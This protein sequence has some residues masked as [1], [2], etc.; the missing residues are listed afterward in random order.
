MLNLVEI[1]LIKR[2][3]EKLR[4][5]QNLKAHL[6]QSGANYVQQGSAL[7]MS[8]VLARLLTPEHFGQFAFAMAYVQLSFMPI[9]FGLDQLLVSKGKNEGDYP[10]VMTV[11]YLLTALGIM[12]IAG[13]AVWLH[14]A[15]K[16]LTAALCVLY[17][18]PEALAPVL[19]AIKGDLE[20]SGNFRQNMEGLLWSQGAGFVAAVVG[21]LSGLGVYALCVP[22]WLTVLSRILVYRRYATRRMF[23]TPVFSGLREI[24]F[25]GAGLWLNNAAQIGMS[26]IDKWFIGTYTGTEALGYYNRAFNYAPLSQMF[27]MSLT[28]NPSVAALARMESG[29]QQKRYLAKITT[30]SLGSGALSFLVWFFGAQYLVVWM[31]GGQWIDAIPVFKALA[32]LAFF[33]SFLGLPRTVCMAYRRYVYMG[34]VRVFSLLGIFLVLFFLKDVLSKSIFLVAYLV[35]LECLIEGL[36]L[37]AGA[38]F[39]INGRRNEIR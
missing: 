24:G 14:G 23:P 25:H 13:L 10:K 20:G 29:E 28:T 2:L 38:I 26:R 16:D 33:Q 17:G 15:G 34:V 6:W 1:F 3:K 39:Y 37:W 36:F 11:A 22:A 21:A 27:L 4:H 18:L 30:I 32:A 5:R 19:N 8:M 31:F 7:V 35:Q 12:I 9:S